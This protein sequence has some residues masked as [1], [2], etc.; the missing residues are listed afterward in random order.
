MAQRISRAKSS[1]KSSGIPF[2]L[3]TREER[4]QRLEAVLHVLYLIFNEGY[5]S[6][7][8]PN[9]LRN[10]LAHE[11]MRI[12]RIVHKLQPDD[13]EVAGLLALMLLTDARRLARASAEGELIPLTQQDR[14]LWNQP[15]IAEGV[16]LLSA[17]LPKGSVG[18]YQLQAAIAAV[19]DEAARAEDTDWPQILA[20][21]DLL[22]RM[23]DN[24]M[25]ALNHAIAAAMVHGPGKGLELLDSLQTDARL[26]NHHRIDAVRAHLLELTGDRQGAATNYRAAA[27]KTESLP[28]RNYLLTQ[29]ARL[30]NE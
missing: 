16:A 23:S 2:Q 20:L 6:S 17:T 18:P 9:L 22:K 21:Y 15:Q 30:S 8:G 10:D 26:A 24:P 13:P 29:A 4:A 28:E 5:T 1:I 14:A 11:A 7:A 27:A 25:V 12:T 19:H 3:P